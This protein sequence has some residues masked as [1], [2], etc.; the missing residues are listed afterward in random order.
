[1]NSKQ[2]GRG[3]RTAGQVV[4]DPGTE[5][6]RTSLGVAGSSQVDTFSTAKPGA[7]LIKLIDLIE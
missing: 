7:D 2:W 3:S 1:M 6:G 5:R 4:F